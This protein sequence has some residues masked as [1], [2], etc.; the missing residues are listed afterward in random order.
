MNDGQENRRSFR[1][2]ESAYVRFEILTDEEFREG[3]EHRKLRLG[4]CDSAQAQ[5]VDIEA[6]LSEEMFRLGGTFEQVGKCLTLLND[7]LNVVIEQLP[8]LRQTKAALASTDPLTCDV[9]ADGLV[10][11]CK[12]KIEVGA[13]LYIQILL[14]SDKRYIDTFCK[15]VRHATTPAGNAPDLAFGIAVEFL[16][17]KASQREILIQHMFNRESETLR[18]RRLRLEDMEN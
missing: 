1:V 15:V 4:D 14:A 2:T 16:D 5:L 10:F 13:M 9:S 6:H 12:D 7:K 11:P 3:L 18:M 17:M 8:G